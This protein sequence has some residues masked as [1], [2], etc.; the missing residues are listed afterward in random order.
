[1]SDKEQMR[2]MMPMKSVEIM[3]EVFVGGTAEVE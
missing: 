2:S 1:M 3:P